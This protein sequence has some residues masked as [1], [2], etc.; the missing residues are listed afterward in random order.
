MFAKETHDEFIKIKQTPED[1]LNFLNFVVNITSFDYKGYDYVIDPERDYFKRPDGKKVETILNS[2]DAAI[3]KAE[4]LFNK[5]QE[6]EEFFDKDFGPQLNDNDIGNKFS[7]YLNG[8]C[9][10]GHMDPS[11]IDW[12]RMT[13][14]SPDKPPVFFDDNIDTNDVMQ[15]ALGDC[16][17]ISALSVIATKDH[18]LRGQFEYSIVDD[19]EIDDQENQ[20]L[21]TGVY[22]PIFHGFRR[23][24]IFIFKFFKN[25]KWRY[26]IIDDRLPVLPVIE[27]C[28]FQRS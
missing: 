2:E 13:Q 15:G 17:F 14:I 11:L 9:P 28:T 10:K 4:E 6:N 21:S 18:L 3:K 26:V 25:C 27:K 1:K 20:M 24:N 23:K 16:W 5:I 8:T 22:P 12:Y 19:G 7:L